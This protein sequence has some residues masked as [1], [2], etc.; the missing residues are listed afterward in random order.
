MVAMR[1]YIYFFKRRIL[2][3]ENEKLNPGNNI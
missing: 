2:Q 1:A 3:P